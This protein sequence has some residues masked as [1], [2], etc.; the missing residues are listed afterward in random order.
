MSSRNT[1]DLRSTGKKQA[2]RDPQQLPLLPD[3]PA[4]TMASTKRTSPV[5]AR[6]RRVRVIIAG[7]ILV[8]L[9]LGVY[10]IGWASYLP[11]YSVDSVNVIGTQTVPSKLVYDYVQTQLYK[12]VYTF[13]SKD[14]IFLYNPQALE[15]EV[16]GFF[17][18][19][20]SVSI[21]RSSLLATAITVT[22]HERQPYALWCSDDTQ[23]NCYEMDTTGFIFAQ[24]SPAQA[25]SASNIVVA[26]STTSA[27]STVAS[28]S[29][30]PQTNQQF[31][32]EGGFATS[33][34]STSS[35]VIT[36]PIGH[37]FEGAHMPGIITL[38]N[39]LGQA[40]FTPTGASVENDQDF[41]VPLNTSLP[42]GGQGFYIKVSFGENPQTIVNNLNLVLSSDALSGKENQL[43]YVDL[44][45]GDRVY[46][47]LQGSAQMQGDS[48]KH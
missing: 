42:A 1:I 17:P 13:L 11:Q 33:T 45:F 36:N 26:S 39:D 48:S 44:R 7:L 34:Q 9:G 2:V 6:R 10:G 22:V 12:G 16:V 30:P 24:A 46:Y 38:L 40:G 27:S 35:L 14:N 3:K 28:T 31:I 15:R 18:R 25:S 41:W 32:F 23:T 20:A 21:S 37:Q 19:I 4:R 29:M 43:E 8:L 47:K 5:R